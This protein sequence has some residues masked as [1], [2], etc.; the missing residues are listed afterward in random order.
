MK[1]SEKAVK[2]KILKEFY[3]FGN[4]KK[5]LKNKNKEKL[6]YFLDRKFK[7]EKN[8]LKVNHK[9]IFYYLH[10]SYKHY[11]YKKKFYKNYSFHKEVIDTLKRI[12]RK[13]TLTHRY[14]IEQLIIEMKK[15]FWM[16]TISN[17][18]G[19]LYSQKKAILKA[20]KVITQ[21]VKDFCRKHNKPFRY[22]AV[23]EI[24]LKKNNQ[25]VSLHLHFYLYDELFDYIDPF[26][27]YGN[28]KTPQQIYQE[29]QREKEKLLN[30]IQ[31]KLSKFLNSFSINLKEFSI[32]KWTKKNNYSSIMHN[33]RYKIKGDKEVI[34]I[35][36]AIIKMFGKK[37][38]I[39]NSRLP[40]SFT[41]LKKMMKAWIYLLKQKPMSYFDL[42]KNN[43]NLEWLKN[44]LKKINIFI[45][46]K[47]LLNRIEE[48]K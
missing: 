36:Y 2:L 43:F 42:L 13:I 44:F 7:K 15:N 3:S 34:Y 20:R 12:D 6:P 28:R 21:T 14:Y 46:T 30:R 16:M 26:D 39:T 25:N 31:K 40:V 8:Y 45:I 9:T 29:K 11:L 47:V 5:D 48:S 24:T 38:F 35:I 41:N 18:R 1:E 33:I 27:E 22:L 4:N 23:P 19:N 17:I 10:K 32:D 37:R